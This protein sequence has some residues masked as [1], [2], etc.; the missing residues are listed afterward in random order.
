MGFE[1]QYIVFYLIFGFAGLFLGWL[2]RNGITIL[3]LI[4]LVCVYP[5]IQVLSD[6]N[7]LQFTICFIVGFLIHTWKPI[8]HKFKSL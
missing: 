8:Y 1:F 4:C 5:F 3:G 6:I 7:E 2:F